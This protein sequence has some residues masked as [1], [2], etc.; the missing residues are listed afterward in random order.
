[1]KRCEVISSE[2]TKALSIKNIKKVF[3][4]MGMNST[5]ALPIAMSGKRLKSVRGKNRG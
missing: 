4:K 5:F 1:V 3:G 2:P